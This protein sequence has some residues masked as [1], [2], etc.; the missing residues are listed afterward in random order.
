MVG[1]DCK[2]D[3]FSCLSSEQVKEQAAHAQSMSSK[4]MKHFQAVWT[5]L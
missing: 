3:L 5:Q 1:A 4:G 2:L